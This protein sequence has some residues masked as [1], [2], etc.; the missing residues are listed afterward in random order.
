[1]SRLRS[2]L[3]L[4]H[5]EQLL[6]GEA[7]LLVAITRLGLSLVP[8]HLMWRLSHRF[9]RAAGRSGRG[10]ATGERNGWA[11]AAVSHYVPAATCLTQALATRVLLER[12][13]RPSRLCIGVAR[14]QG[15]QLEAHAWVESGG[16]IVVGAIDDLNR[17]TP[18]LAVEEVIP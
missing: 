13:G 9:A 14:S 4:P 5:A 8:F 17:F 7:A 11:V 6:L 12:Y 16:R 18:L 2:F 3:R 15:Q 1:M 10:G